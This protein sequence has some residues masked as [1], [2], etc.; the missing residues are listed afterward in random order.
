MIVL[1]IIAWVLCAAITYG[2]LMHVDPDE[3]EDEP[4]L[5]MFLCVLIWPLFVLIGIG[6]VILSRLSKIGMFFAGF[7]DKALERKEDEDDG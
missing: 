2:V 5:G 7:L 6:I 3:M 1:G 4:L